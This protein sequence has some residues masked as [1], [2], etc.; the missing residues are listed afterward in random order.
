MVIISYKKTKDGAVIVEE[1]VRCEE[2]IRCNLDRYHEFFRD[3]PLWGGREWKTLDVPEIVE[4]FHNAAEEGLVYLK[5][6]Q[7]ILLKEYSGRNA[8]VKLFRKPPRVSIPTKSE[9]LEEMIGR[10]RRLADWMEKNQSRRFF[11]D[12]DMSVFIVKPRAVASCLE[13]MS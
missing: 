7:D 3:V 5:N 10:C 11:Y 9:L 2:P 8:L 12:S 13:K 4:I 6:E 1:K